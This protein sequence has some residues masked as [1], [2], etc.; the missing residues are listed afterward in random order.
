MSSNIESINIDFCMRIFF[1]VCMVLG[2]FLGAGFVS[3]REI[4]SYFSRFG[5]ASIYAIMVAVVI[6]FSLMLFFFYISSRV[7]N[8]NDFCR[9][10]FGATSNIARGLM[11][12]CVLIV[13]SSMFAGT[14]SLSETFG[15]N[16]IVF[17]AITTILAYTIVV[18]KVERLQNVSAVLIP[19]LLTIVIIVTICPLHI[20][21]A[22]GEEVVLSM[23]SGGNYI[24]INI[25]SL[26]IFL[27]EIGYKYSPK[28]KIWISLLS[29][30]IIGIMILLI[31]NAILS[32]NCITDIFPTLSL[33]RGRGVLFLAMQL[34]IFFG[35]FTTL[36]SNALIFSRYL[37]SF[38]HS[39]RISTIITLIIGIALSSFGFKQIVGYIYWLIGLIGVVMVFVAVFKEKGIWNSPHS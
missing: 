13:L 2:C 8:I 9:V 20:T 33:S 21:M 25:V 27:L 5:D 17:T 26:G 7:D 32:S 31:N 12:F 34:S 3:G 14:I 28:E 19:F 36:V 22:R 11:A 6:L 24:F 23:A 1:G 16:K 29:S 10:Y 39:R 15:V 18:G 4:A 35:L 37:S 30:I 38:L